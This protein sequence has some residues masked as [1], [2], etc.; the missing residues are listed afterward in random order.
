[1][2]TKNEKARRARTKLIGQKPDCIST[3]KKSTVVAQLKA[4]LKNAQIKLREKQAEHDEHAVKRLNTI[5]D[6]LQQTI[7]RQA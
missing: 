4:D 7:A 3:P 5:I 2:P 1:M 6:N